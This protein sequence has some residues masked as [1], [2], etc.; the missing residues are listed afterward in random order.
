[1][2]V[3]NTQKA[4][5]AF[6]RAD[7]LLRDTFEH[8]YSP[9]RFGPPA[10]PQDTSGM[11]RRSGRQHASSAAPST[12]PIRTPKRIGQRINAPYTACHL[13]AAPVETIEVFENELDQFCTQPPV[14]T[15]D[16]IRYMYCESVAKRLEHVADMGMDYLSA[17]GESMNP[18]PLRIFLA[19]IC[20]TAVTVLG[21]F[22]FCPRETSLNFFKHV[23][24][25]GFLYRNWHELGIIVE[26]THIAKITSLLELDTSWDI[27]PEVR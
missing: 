26:A 23:V 4:D 3:H 1:M 24:R 12:G 13:N 15:K 8:H 25:T 16:P 19:N 11:P 17:S 22:P 6:L 21:R 7:Q 20:T 5:P 2:T 18:I 10:P 27:E 9:D 14:S